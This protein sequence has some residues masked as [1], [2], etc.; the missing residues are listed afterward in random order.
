[1]TTQREM[2]RRDNRGTPR[3]SFAD[4]HVQQADMSIVARLVTRGGAL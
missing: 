3:E 2:P 1:M 4:N